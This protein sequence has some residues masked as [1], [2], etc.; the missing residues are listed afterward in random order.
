MTKGL[1]VFTQAGYFL[2]LCIEYMYMYFIN[3]CRCCIVVLLVITVPISPYVNSSLTLTLYRHFTGSLL[4]ATQCNNKKVRSLLS[5]T[6][7]R[8][9]V[10]LFSAEGN[11]TQPHLLHW[12]MVKVNAIFPCILTTTGQMKLSSTPSFAPRPW[13]SQR[14]RRTYVDTGLLSSESASLMVSYYKVIQS[15][16]K[17]QKINR[18]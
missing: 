11:K 3:A 5:Y 15:K 6:T 7:A 2:D 17:E 10:L 14:H 12:A 8:T 4:N 16:Y 1:S 9:M 13:G 18:P